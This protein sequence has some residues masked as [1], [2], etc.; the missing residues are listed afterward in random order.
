MVQSTQPS[1]G[2]PKFVRRVGGQFKPTAFADWFQEKLGQWGRSTGNPHATP[3][4]FRKTALQHARIGEDLN[5]RVAE[6]AKLNESVMIAHYVT[7]RD[8]ELRH[9]S[10]RTYRRIVASLP[11][12]VARR[13]GYFADNGVADLRLKL[14]K[15]SQAQDWALVAKLAEQLAQQ[16]QQ[17][18][19]GAGSHE[20][21]LG[22]G[23]QGSP[24][25]LGEPQ[26]SA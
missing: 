18:H 13:Y 20:C 25:V 1:A 12:H 6:D 11:P 21:P 23:H 9:A 2:Q 24:V 22:P 10:N 8:E 5:R 26:P 7:E 4:V 17:E 14:S 3:H 15:A 19:P 16:R